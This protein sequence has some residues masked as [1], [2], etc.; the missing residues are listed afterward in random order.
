MN[1]NKFILQVALA[2]FLILMA[3]F[4]GQL[5]KLQKQWRSAVRI[6]PPASEP[7]L[8]D[9]TAAPIG[10]GSR[11]AWRPIHASPEY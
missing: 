6:M 3:A 8:P 2:V 1:R 7:Y 9:T 11:Q 4:A 10:T 5:R